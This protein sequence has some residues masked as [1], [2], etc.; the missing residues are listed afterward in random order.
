MSNFGLHL[1]TIDKTHDLH[2][3]YVKKTRSLERRFKLFLSQLPHSPDFTVMTP[4]YVCRFFVWSDEFG[5]FKISRGFV[6]V[7]RY[8][9]CTWM[10]M[11]YKTCNGNYS[12]YDPTD[13][14]DFANP[15]EKPILGCSIKNMVPL[16]INGSKKIIWSSV[17][18]SRQNLMCCQNKLN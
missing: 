8:Y 1:L 18:R 13:D 5:K 3:C 9:G 16:F 12:E 4:Q 14:G 11:S 10:C 15:W 2:I 7:L 17:K 6:P